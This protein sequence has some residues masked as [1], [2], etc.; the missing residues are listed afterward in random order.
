ME[1]IV[2]LS[3][4]EFSI[5]RCASQANN[6]VDHP[7]MNI[8]LQSLDCLY[9]VYFSNCMCAFWRCSPRD[10]ASNELGGHEDDV[11]LT[12]GDF[13][14]INVTE[15]SAM[16]SCSLFEKLAVPSNIQV[17]SSNHYLLMK[18]AG[19]LHKENS[20]LKKVYQEKYNSK[21]PRQRMQSEVLQTLAP[22]K[23]E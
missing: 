17:P 2:D 10:T 3:R 4:I 13:S 11:S 22:G 14:M 1:I 9:Q 15:T 18:M 21:L 8:S 20:L 16:Q 7:L 12:H 19:Q 23:V 6:I 5:L